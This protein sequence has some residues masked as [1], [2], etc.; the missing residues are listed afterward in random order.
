[1]RKCWIIAVLCMLLAG[2]GSKEVFETLGN[3]QHE[4]SELPAM[5]AVSLQ[6]PEE[7]AAEAFG[8]GEGTLYE[9][10]GYTL[11]LQTVASGDFARTVQTLSGF[12]PEKLTILE[13]KVGQA[14]RYD[15][16]WT[17]AGE[18]GDVLCRATVLDDGK[19]HYCLTAVADARE[20]GNLTAHWNELFGSFCLG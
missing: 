9:C 3:V 14:Q 10:E 20:A 13:S 11:V 7:A 12:Q 5:A 15:W 17:A 1:M 6:L 4:N 8:S 18:D 16:V 2:C 19:Y